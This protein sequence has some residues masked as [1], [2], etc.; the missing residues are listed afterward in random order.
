MLRQYQY[1]KMEHKRHFCLQQNPFMLFWLL[2]LKKDT[3]RSAN[4]KGFKKWSMRWIKSKI[5]EYYYFSRTI[6]KLISFVKYK[7]RLQNID[8]L[9][10]LPFYGQICVL[11][12]K[13]YKIFDLRRRVVIKVYRNDVDIPTITEELDCLK[14]GSLFDFAPSIRKINIKDRWYEEDYISGSLDYS[15]IQR[16]SSDLLEKFYR[17][18]FPCLER[19]L[20]Y[21]SPMKKYTIY[22]MNEIK[23]KLSSGNLLKE[24]LDT[25]QIDQIRDFIHSM[26][27]R[28]HSEGNIPFFLVLT[29]GDF[30]P[31]NMLNTRHGLRVIDWESASLRSALFDFYSYF[32]YRPFH[33]FHP[34]PVNKLCSEI[35]AALPFIIS[36]LEPASL[37]IAGSVKSYE[38][39]YRWLYYIERVYMLIERER[40]ETK[41]NTMNNILRYIEVFNSYEEICID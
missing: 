17:D 39:V 40:Y 22:Y 14:N 21:H 5:R 12:N 4:I 34:L 24:G 6:F 18:V 23:T 19:L 1:I 28:L 10:E 15:V 32:F 7:F 31:A 26:D 30:C 33:K 36:K 11:V 41:L 25:E 3:L 27:E 29:H 35:K 20:L 2:F 8:S 16:N 9:V 38:K 37:E 13:G